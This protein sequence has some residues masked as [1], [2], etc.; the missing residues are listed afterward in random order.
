MV[1]KKIVVI[2]NKIERC[3]N[4]KFSKNALIVFFMMLPGALFGAAQPR[5][6]AINYHSAGV[7]PL[8]NPGGGQT[9]LLFTPN[10]KAGEPL[11]SDAGAT[12]STEKHPAVTAAQGFFSRQTRYKTVKELAHAIKDHGTPLYMG[13]HISYL[14]PVHEHDVKALRAL[15]ALDHGVISVPMSNLGDA[16]RYADH[17]RTSRGVKVHDWNGNTWTLYDKFVEGLLHNRHR[18]HGL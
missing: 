8:Y 1:L 3:K 17:R 7:I 12:K 6:Q 15:C 14:F 16:L 9:A 2:F 10:P 4:M 11:F 13:S 18:I 5:K